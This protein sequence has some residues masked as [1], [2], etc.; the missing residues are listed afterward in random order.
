MIGWMGLWTEIKYLTGFS[1]LGKRRRVNVRYMEK[2]I[3]NRAEDIAN[4]EQ[5]IQ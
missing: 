4:L 2:A 3:F 5:L 1:R